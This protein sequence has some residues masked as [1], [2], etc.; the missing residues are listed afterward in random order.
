MLLFSFKIASRLRHRVP[1]WKLESRQRG[2]DRE[3]GSAGTRLDY[4]EGE[5]V[6]ETLTLDWVEGKEAR[7]GQTQRG[8]IGVEGEY[9]ERAMVE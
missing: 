9:L 1:K 4:L 7:L 3:E 8:S 5:R 2:L 6:K